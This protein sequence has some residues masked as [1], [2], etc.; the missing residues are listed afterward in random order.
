MSRD[1]VEHTKLETSDLTAIQDFLKQN[2]GNLEM[3]ELTIHSSA[4]TYIAELRPT[5]EP[6]S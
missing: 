5:N 1:R 6:S 2:A 4:G 3:A